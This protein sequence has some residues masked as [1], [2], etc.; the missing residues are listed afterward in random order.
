M[1]YVYGSANIDATIF[2]GTSKKEVSF[3][4]NFSR[5]TSCGNPSARCSNGVSN[6]RVASIFVVLMVY[7]IALIAG[8]TRVAAEVVAGAIFLQSP[9]IPR[10]PSALGD[11]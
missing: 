2:N 9:V 7:R 11:S 5:F 3:F 8:C 4:L 10:E 6:K 1:F